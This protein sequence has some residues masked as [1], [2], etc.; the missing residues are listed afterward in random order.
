MLK[1]SVSILL[2]MIMI[3]SVFTIIPTSAAVIED[4]SVEAEI[5]SAADETETKESISVVDD[6]VE[7]ESNND[8]IVTPISPENNA[9]KISEETETVSSNES[10]SELAQTGADE[11]IAET[12]KSSFTY[13]VS[14]NTVTITGLSD[15][16]LTDLVIPETIEGYSVTTIKDNAFNGCSQITSITVPNCVT[17]IGNGAFKGTNPTKIT[18][19]FIGMTREANGTSAVFGHIFGYS[20]STSYPASN[21]EK[22]YQYYDNT[23]YY[24]YEIPKTIK[25]VIITDDV[26]VPYDAFYNCDWIESIRTCCTASLFFVVEK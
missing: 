18:L 3:L 24:L 26:R 11:V 19:P 9:E 5:S 8:I 10:D 15:E 6:S 14:N 23:Y 17:S 22:V 21:E 25:E 1:K 16:Y 20:R 2:S 12:G 4:T 7:I 13:T